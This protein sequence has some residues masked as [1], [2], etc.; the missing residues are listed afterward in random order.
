MGVECC[1]MLEGRHSNR[2]VSRGGVGL[3]TDTRAGNRSAR[4]D[5][6]KVESSMNFG[7]QSSRQQSESESGLRGTDYERFAAQEANRAGVRQGTLYQRLSEGPGALYNFG[8]QMLPGG[9]FGLGESLDQAVS[10]LGNQLFGR[11][12]ASGAARGMV[13]P[14][15]LG[16]ILGSAVTNALPMILPALQGFQQM[17][18]GA[19]QSLMSMARSVGDY[20]T[21][22]LGSKSKGSGKGE[23]VNASIMS[24]ES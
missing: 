6:C 9:R 12:S 21:S 19:P 22:T 7:A 2:E 23:G 13:S 18:F 8:K 1:G 10:E 4:Y 5:N 17:Q 15:N 14:L 3:P 24:G 11:A 16:G 20:W